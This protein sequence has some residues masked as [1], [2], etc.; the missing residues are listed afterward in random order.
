MVWRAP[1]EVSGRWLLA[2]DLLSSCCLL[3]AA[4]CWL[5]A[6]G[7][8]AAGI[9]GCWNCWF[10]SGCKLLGASAGMAG[11]FLAASCWVLASP[12]GCWLAGWLAGWLLVAG[13]L[14]WLLVVAFCETRPPQTFAE[15]EP[16]SSKSL[17][18]FFYMKNKQQP[19]AT[20]E[21]PR[22]SSEAAQEKPRNSSE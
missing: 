11:F 9:A 20:P 6:A 17:T 22:R 8:I 3:P 10:V 21:A 4:V 15:E 14:F 2:A 16:A 19:G 1:E 13:Y 5:L 18:Q 12:A 7:L